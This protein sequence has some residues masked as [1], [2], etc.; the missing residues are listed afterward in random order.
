MPT[1]HASARPRLRQTFGVVVTAYLLAAASPLAIAQPAAP[2]KLEAPSRSTV[3]AFKVQPIER[4][5]PDGQPIRG[6]LATI[7][8][9]DPR[10][11]IVVTSA[12]EQPIEAAPSAEARLE[13]V[14]VWARRANVDLAINANFFGRADRA[15]EFVLNAPADIIGLSVSDAKVISPPREFKG[16]GDPALVFG[17]D[18]RASVVRQGATLTGDVFDAVAGIGGSESDPTRGDQLVTAGTSTADTARVEPKARHPRT[19]AGVSKDGWTLYLVTIDGRQKDW[20]VGMTL[21]EL[22]A[23]LIELGSHDAINLDGGGSTTMIYREPGSSTYQTNRPSEKSG[24]RPV[25]NALGIRIHQ[26]AEKPAE[27]APPK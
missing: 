26:P 18:R 5:A 15:K 20:S 17:K 13:P 23:L 25:A 10:V 3:P 27:G 24:F 7:D 22:A 9:R 1:A 11:E 12:L 6:L 16:K 8:L 19:A 21:P 14:D 4:R 2:A